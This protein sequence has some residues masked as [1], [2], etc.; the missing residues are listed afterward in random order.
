MP[1]VKP[2]FSQGRSSRAVIIPAS[3]LDYEEEK[4]G[5]KIT[6]VYMDVV[7]DAIIIRPGRPVK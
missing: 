4:R 7:R 2:I 6:H 5:E 3:W 1:L